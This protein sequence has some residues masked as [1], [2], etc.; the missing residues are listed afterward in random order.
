MYQT[1]KQKSFF[2]GLR[3]EVFSVLKQKKLPAIDGRAMLTKALVC[4]TMWLAGYLGYLL[5]GYFYSWYSLFLVIPCVFGMLCIVLGVMHDG[6]H[7]TFSEKK[8]LN[9]LA[10][11]S[12]GF[13][14]GSALIWHQSH[15]RDHHDNTNV[16]HFDQD[17][18]SGGLLRL[19]PAQKMKTA[20]RF[21][22]YYAWF[23][24]LGFAL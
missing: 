9:K 23:L 5:V 6:S 1:T 12:L 3:K 20:F 15:V 11:Q 4:Y 14:G 19:H 21:Q 22:H 8:W 10:A 2:Q 13:A 24:Y 16:M 18:E 7:G 17:F